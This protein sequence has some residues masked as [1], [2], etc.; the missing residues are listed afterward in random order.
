MSG[1][2]P[3][4]GI[5]MG[6]PAGVGPEI[7]V[8][9][10]SN[11]EVCQKCRPVVIGDAEVIKDALRFTGL[12]MKI[13]RISDM[14]DACYEFGIINVFDLSN[15]DMKKLEY[16]KVSAMAGNAAFEAVKKLIEL[17]MENKIDATITG[18]IN[19]EAINLAGHHFS[20]HTEIFAHFTKTDDYSMMLAHE[21]FRV[22][23][24]STHVPLRQAC[25]LIRKE[26]VL[27]V[28]MLA[29]EACNRIGI[30]SPKIGVAGL[31][32]HSGE[33]GMFGWEEEKEII[34][35]I[36]EAIKLGM[37]VDG[38]VP[39]DSLF[40]KARGGWYDIVVAMYHDQGHIPMK[41]VGFQWSKNHREW[42][43]ISGVNI[44]LGL[45]IIRSSVDHGTA[46][47]KAGLGIASE[48]SLIQAIEYGILLAK[49]K[50]EKPDPE[51]QADF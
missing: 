44:T 33:N 18:P 28:I 2:K 49:N 40:P 1:Y 15:V 17:A 27:K 38:P 22:V 23:H 51:N 37:K 21:S 10:L 35:A 32:P 14:R 3:I 29:Q 13:N 7:A 41:M 48:M 36:K 26:R 24:V 25:D 5:S 4:L 12:S 6:D 42:N 8:K 34:P 20:G 11:P 50:T 9:A 30:H 47:D 43:A 16:G 31:N 19:K 45:P 46:F 39:P